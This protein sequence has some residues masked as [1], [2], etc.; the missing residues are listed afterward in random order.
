M[1]VNDE[2]NR[3]TFSDD[4]NESPTT[5]EKKCS[6]TDP[7]T[8]QCFRHDAVSVVNDPRDDLSKFQEMT[9]LKT[10]LWAISRVTLS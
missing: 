3:C 8:R 7:S 1:F 10:L 4:I 9:H 2:R 5:K 6:L